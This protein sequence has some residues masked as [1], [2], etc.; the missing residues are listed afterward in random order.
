MRAG[1][2]DVSGAVR[3]VRRVAEPA[4]SREDGDGEPGRGC[5]ARRARVRRARGARGRSAALRPEPPAHAPLEQAHATTATTTGAAQTGT[6][7]APVDSTGPSTADIATDRVRIH[8]DR[9]RVALSGRVDPPTTDDT[10]VKRST[11]RA[12]PPQPLIQCP[13]G[14]PPYDAPLRP[15]DLAA[16]GAWDLRCGPGP[17]GGAL[18]SMLWEPRCTTW[19]S[20]GTPGTPA[21]C[22]GARPDAAPGRCWSA[23]SCSSRPRW[24]GY[25][26]VY[27][28]WLERWPTPGRPRRGAPR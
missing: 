7:H 5:A 6:R 12:D 4:P 8:T 9:W 10:L 19:S 26:P 18:G 2:W 13:R 1:A 17:G 11:N 16:R 20:T 27:E 15:P 23:S 24:S 25:C 14:C 22:R 3:A 21:T 28:E